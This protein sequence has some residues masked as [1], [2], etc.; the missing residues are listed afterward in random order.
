[1]KFINCAEISFKIRRKKLF[2]KCNPLCV[3][4]IFIVDERFFIL[5]YRI[6]KKERTINMKKQTTAI[7]LTAAMLF[8]TAAFAADGGNT[9]VDTVS[10]TAAAS[11][12]Y[13][14]SA[15]SAGIIE[16][17]DYDTTTAV[18]REQFCEFAYNMI[19]SVKELPMAKLA[20][21]PFDDVSNPKINALAF[22]GIVSGKDEYIFAPND[23][24]S[25]EEA[26]VI[27]YRLA[28]Y[29]GTELPMAKVDISYSGN[30]EISPWAVSAVYGLKLSGIISNDSESF[31]PHADYTVGEAVS[32]LVKLN[33]LIKK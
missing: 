24:L 30:S 28:E 5:N 21:A 1:M 13:I 2:K 19:N 10:V 26:A 8:G 33:N 9:A 6:Y 15:L 29:A 22:V 12:D 14:Q 20:R 4:A 32:S 27:L 31:N 18:T 23:K 7:I 16:N 3:S 25:R 11:E 17:K